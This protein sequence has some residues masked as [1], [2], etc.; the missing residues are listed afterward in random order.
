MNLKKMF[1]II[2]LNKFMMIILN[3]I[4]ESALNSSLSRSE[5][6][7]FGRRYSNTDEEHSIRPTRVT[8]SKT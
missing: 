3:T 6:L 2:L 8:I 4:D 1:N 7:V 5:L